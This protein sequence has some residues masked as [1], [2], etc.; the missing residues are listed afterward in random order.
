MA[1]EFEVDDLSDVIEALATGD[2]T[3]TR[4]AATTFSQGRRVA[5]ASSTFEVRAVVYPV[6]GRA[7]DRLPEGLRSHETIAVVTQTELRSLDATKE[8]DLVTYQGAQ[9]QV[10]ILERWKPSGNFHRA[11]CTRVPSS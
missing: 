5:G 11:L 7:L 3:V 2:Y 6:T 8:P 9:Y 4:S 10:A 1:Q